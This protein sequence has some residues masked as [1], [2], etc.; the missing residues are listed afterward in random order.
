[1]TLSNKDIIDGLY[2]HN[3]DVLEYL[4]KE[5]FKNALFFITNNSGNKS[6]AEDIFQDS[7]ITIYSILQEKKLKLRYSFSTFFIGI[8]KNLWYLEIRKR[9]LTKNNIEYSNF[10]EISDSKSLLWGNDDFDEYDINDV[11]IQYE[12]DNLFRYHFE[13]LTVVCKRVLLLY[14][15]KKPMKDIAVATGFNCEKTVKAKKYKCQEELIKNIKNDPEYNR[16]VNIIKIEV[17]EE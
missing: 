1:M 14:F 16:I 2:S 11:V 13:R 15:D 9:R 12:K 17:A 5:N 4:Y 10:L 3:K 7:L 6:D 8:C